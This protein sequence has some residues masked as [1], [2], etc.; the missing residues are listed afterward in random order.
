MS[1]LEDSLYLGAGRMA[2]S[3]AEQVAKI[4][5]I[6]GEQGYENATPDEACTMLRLKVLHQLLPA[7]DSRC[8][9]GL[10]PRGRDLRLTRSV[11]G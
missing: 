4:G 2:T 10:D 9:G 3:N 5:R 8:F 6:L 7:Q 11:L 1:L